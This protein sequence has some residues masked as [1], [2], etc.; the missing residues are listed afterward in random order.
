MLSHS[1]LLFSLFVLLSS[2]I[3]NPEFLSSNSLITSDSDI[4]LSPPSSKSGPIR[5]LILIPGGKVPNENYTSIA[6][7]IQKF[8]SLNLWIGIPHCLMNL[9]DPLDPTSFGLNAAIFRVITALNSTNAGLLQSHQIFIFGHSLGGPGARHFIDFHP[10]FAGLGLLGT[11]YIGDHEDYKGTL[12]YPMNLSAFP[13]PLLALTGELDG[14]PFTHAGSLLNQREI[15]DEDTKNKKVI[16]VIPGMDHSDFCQGFHVSGD[17]VSELSSDFAV[18]SIGEVIGSW[19]DLQ[20]F[21]KDSLNFEN[22]KK[23]IDSYIEKTSVLM[24]PFNEASNLDKKAWC[25]TSQKILSGLNESDWERLIV[26]GIFVD[27]TNFDLEHA[28]PN[29][30]FI[31]ALN[32]TLMINVPSYPY[33]EEIK[34][35][36]YA[37]L[38]SGARDIACKMLSADKIA[39]LLNFEV[40]EVSKQKTCKDINEMAFE[41]AKKLVRNQFPTSFQRFE[42][43]GVFPKFIDDSFPLIGPQWVFLNSLKIDSKTGEVTSPDMYSPLDSWAYPGVRYCKVLSPAKAVEYIM[44]TGLTNRYA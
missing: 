32:T 3:H 8:T 31:D 38:Y 7:S 12:G 36:S 21:N 41:L 9:C 15:L 19:L 28:H 27:G 42:K 25:E 26:N 44:S 22:A 10:E 23:K 20:L 43:Q 1:L 39:N 35:F 17:I 29:Y 11:Q 34:D 14:V 2:I 18:N 30:S 4:L 40:P 13:L 5:V 24:S 33:Y 6:K 37:T 16:I